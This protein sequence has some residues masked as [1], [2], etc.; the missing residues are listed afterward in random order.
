MTFAAG[1]AVQEDQGKLDESLDAYRQVLALDL[2]SLG[3]EHPTVADDHRNLGR[4]LRLARKLP[5]ALQHFERALEIDRKA[6]GPE[7]TALAPDHHGL[8]LTY[9]AQAKRKEAIREL[10]R[11]LKLYRAAAPLHAEGEAEVADA[12]FKLG[13]KR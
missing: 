7:H 3:A 1:W 13:L 10:E 6:F 11:A 8:G 5:E 2:A 4:V 9:L 12:L